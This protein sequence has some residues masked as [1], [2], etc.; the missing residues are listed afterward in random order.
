MI[1]IGRLFLFGISLVG[2]TLSVEGRINDVGEIFC[3][4]V[5]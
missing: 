5:Q 2:L 1:A 3:N 4:D